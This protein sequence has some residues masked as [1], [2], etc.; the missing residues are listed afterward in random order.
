MPAGYG[1]S[2]S[3]NMKSGMRG[4]D[5]AKRSS[6]TGKDEDILRSKGK[7]KFSDKYMNPTKAKKSLKNK[8]KGRSLGSY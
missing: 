3:G 6:K 1:Y 5:Y 2:G 8:A 4:K 7:G